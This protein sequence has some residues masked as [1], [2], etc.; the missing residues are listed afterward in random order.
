MKIA[1]L[2]LLLHVST[3]FGGIMCLLAVVFPVGIR[4]IVVARCRRMLP[5][6]S[7][8]LVVLCQFFTTSFLDKSQVFGGQAR[9]GIIF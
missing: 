7:L 8:M 5:L 2:L 3:S 6:H 4:K 9:A 1:Q